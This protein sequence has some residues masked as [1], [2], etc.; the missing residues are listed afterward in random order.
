MWT[1]CILVAYLLGSVPFGVL[2]AR[3]QGVDIRAQGSRNIGAS[4]VGRVL[5]RRFGL[6]CFGLDFM[7]GAAPVLSAGL[8][9]EVIGAAP[10]ELTAAEMCFWMAVAAAAV[11]GHMFSIFLR[12]GGGK[13]VATGFGAILAM[14][15]LLTFA[16]VAAILAWYVTL[17]ASRYISL[18]SM[19]AAATMP[20]GY[21]ATALALGAFNIDGQGVWGSA[22]H[23]SPPLIGSALLA[24]LVIY[25][26]RGNI[27]RLRHGQEPKV[28]ER[29]HPAG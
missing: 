13:G 14:Y 2:I 19:V 17:R 25:R 12:F 11:V 28:G 15:P 5:G 21:L 4:N 6:L 18:A 20:L 8:V 22:V 1:A 9:N 23:A 10:Q 27:S 16:G 24:S 29:P 3:A 7:K 26:H